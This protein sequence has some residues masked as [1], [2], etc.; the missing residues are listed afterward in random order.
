V[1]LSFS[2]A[3]RDKNDNGRIKKKRPTGN[4][5]QFSSSAH[6]GQH[7]VYNFQDMYNLVNNVTYPKALPWEER[8]HIPVFRGSYWGVPLSINKL[9]K[10]A[11]METEQLI[12]PYNKSAAQDIVKDAYFHRLLNNEDQVYGLNNSRYQRLKLVYTS[13]Q[14]PAL[15]NARFIHSKNNVWSQN[16]TNGLDRVLPFDPIPEEVYYTKFQTHIGKFR[17]MA[18]VL[19]LYSCLKSHGRIF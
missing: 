9:N 18:R 8:H 17:R 16:S 4:K 12:N 7:S 14:Y 11:A 19:L 10:L 5:C 13:I 15:V 3:D 6:K 1:T 2:M